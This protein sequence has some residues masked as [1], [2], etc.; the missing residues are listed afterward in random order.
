MRRAL[1]ALSLLLGACGGEAGAL[2]ADIA[3]GPGPS[4]LK[5]TTAPPRMT[6]LDGATDLWQPGE[7]VPRAALVL[8]PGLTDQ[9]RRDPRV[10]ALAQS[11][12]RGKFLVAVP[13]LPGARAMAV[14][15]SDARPIADAARLLAAHPA[16]PRPGE[17]GVAAISYAAGP[18]LLAARETP[19]MRWLALLGGYADAAHVVRFTT[20]GAHRGP[21]E[22]AW[23]HGTPRPEAAWLFAEANA[24]FLDDPAEGARLA[25]LARRRAQGGGPD[26]AEA[27]LGPQGRAVMALVLNRQPAR[28]D[29]LIAALPERLRAELQALSPLRAGLG[30]IAGCVLLLHGTADPIIPWTEA[31]WLAA[32]LPRARVLLLEDFSH[33]GPAAPGAAAT[34]GLLAG[35]SAL[36]ALR[37]GQ[38]ACL[39]PEAAR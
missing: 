11:L 2:L 10:V 26:G 4:G 36:L 14:R 37:D 25:A 15:A 30:G 33:I 3:A 7:G 12:A 27:A 29:A 6:A 16:N 5:A 28:S 39:S 17:V 35:T 24:A 20:T 34:Q 18:A 23:R 38:D 1:L 13:E 8:V 32:S 9:G 22:A 19:E 21:G 31:K